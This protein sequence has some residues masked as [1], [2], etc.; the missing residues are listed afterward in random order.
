MGCGTGVW[1]ATFKRLY[2]N[3]RVLSAAISARPQDHTGIIG[4]RQ[5]HTIG[6]IA[7]GRAR[8]AGSIYDAD[9]RAHVSSFVSHIPSAGPITQAN[10]GENNIYDV[11]VP[12]IGDR[13]FP[14]CGGQNR[15]TL[16]F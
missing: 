8:V 6:D 11:P 9:C 7:P 3:V 15:A 4:L 13:L 10:V 2:E 14:A 1:G 5:E 12:Q 16:F